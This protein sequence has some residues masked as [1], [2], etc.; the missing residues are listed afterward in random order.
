MHFLRFGNGTFADDD[1][2][3]KTFTHVN[4]LIGSCRHQRAFD[5]DPA[6]MYLQR[7]TNS[8]RARATIDD[9]CSSIR[10][11]IGATKVDPDLL[12]CAE[13]C[14]MRAT[15]GARRPTTP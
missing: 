1:F 14:N 13:S 2:S 6:L 7:A 15:C 12:T 3:M 8:L 4:D 5:D 10:A 11:A 9:F